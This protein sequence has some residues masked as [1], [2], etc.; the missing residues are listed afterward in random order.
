MRYERG[1]EDALLDGQRRN[2]QIRFFI[3]DAREFRT[4]EQLFPDRV[5]DLAKRDQ[6]GNLARLGIRPYR[7]RGEKEAGDDPRLCRTSSQF[8]SSHLN[9]S[10]SRILAKCA[11]RHKSAMPC[12]GCPAWR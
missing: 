10:M 8:V 1:Y 6:V 2:V 11:A 3:P 12:Q 5:V 7:V 9:A 4:F